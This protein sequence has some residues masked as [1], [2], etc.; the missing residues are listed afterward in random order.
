MGEGRQGRTT[1][2]CVPSSIAGN[3]HRSPCRISKR[4]GPATDG[5]NSKSYVS[6][7]PM[8]TRAV[9]ATRS[10]CGSSAPSL[11][12]GRQ[13]A[14]RT[15][16]QQLHPQN[17]AGNAHLHQAEAIGLADPQLN[18]RTICAAIDDVNNA[19]SVRSENFSE[20]ERN[21]MRRIARV[22]RLAHDE[23]AGEARMLLPHSRRR[24]CGR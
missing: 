3:G 23:S 19:V 20:H 24:A 4:M 16:A 8:R 22:A 6:P 18:R 1:I 21:V 11:P 2:A 15:V 5:V 10:D 17:G 7:M 14:H 13:I 12:T 9:D